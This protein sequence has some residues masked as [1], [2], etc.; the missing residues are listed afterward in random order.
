MTK[1]PVAVVAGVGS[2]TGEALVR[3]F[4]DGG[5]RVAM[6]ARKE[7]RLTRIAGDVPDAV[8]YPCDMADI[9]GLRATLERIKQEMGLP[10][11]AI[12]NGA[13][14]VREHYTKST[15]WSSRARS[16]STRRR[17]SY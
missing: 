14:A 12:H 9:D 17:Y 2:G 8:S 11:V 3:R 4:A 5:Y 16:A 10:K 1:K 15:R 6:I 7:E 13:K